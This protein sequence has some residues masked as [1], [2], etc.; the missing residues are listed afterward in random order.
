MKSYQPKTELPTTEH[1]F[2]ITVLW[3]GSKGEVM[4][5][6]NNITC[7]RCDEEIAN[8]APNHIHTN[9]ER[10]FHWKCE[11]ERQKEAKRKAAGQEE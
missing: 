2:I 9:T 10:H 5:K 4:V 1:P 8:L 11:E 7:D 6:E 3:T